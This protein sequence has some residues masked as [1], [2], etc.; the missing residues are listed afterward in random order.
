MRRTAILLYGVIS[1]GVFLASFLYAVG[2]LANVAVPKSIDSGT[3]GPVLAAL[4]IDAALLSLFAVQHTGMARRAFKRWLVAV[5]PAS[6]ER[7]TYVLASSVALIVLYWQWRPLPATI[8]HVGDPIARGVLWAICAIGWATVL[9]GTFMI[10]HF[11]LFGL[12]QVWAQARREQVVHPVF[13]TRWLYKYV[14][15]PLMFG[16]L[17]AFWATPDMT[18]G[19]LLFA[20]GSTG[21]IVIA[22]L[23]FEERDLE[24]EHGEV[25]RRYR[26]R[27]PAFIPHVGHGVSV[28]D[29]TPE[30]T[31]PALQERGA[32]AS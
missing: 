17:V 28:G 22:T 1:Y 15:H 30:G 21:Y 27:V 4:L 25:Y 29:L 5:V 7:S 9:F 6:M 24:R 32:N 18:V 8:W 20:A 11:N 10:N 31:E 3:P 14:R 26:E 19:H 12:S 16:F 23:G 2:F 13:Q